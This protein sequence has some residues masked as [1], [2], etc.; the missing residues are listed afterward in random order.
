MIIVFLPAYIVHVSK[1]GFSISPNTSQTKDNE[2]YHFARNFC[3][4]IVLHVYIFTTVLFAKYLF[5]RKERIQREKNRK[6]K[7]NILPKQ[8]SQSESHSRH[9]STSDSI[10]KFKK[11]DSTK[12]GWVAIIS[13]YQGFESFMNH[14]EKEFSMENL[15]FIQEVLYFDYSFVFIIFGRKKFHQKFLPLSAKNCLG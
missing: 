10:R 6:N 9:D 4:C 14:L 15:L 2:G 11:R 8:I 5:R 1:H 3:L 13:H 7:E 12:F